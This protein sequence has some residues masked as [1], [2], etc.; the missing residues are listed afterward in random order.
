M[1]KIFHVLKF[2]KEEFIL[3]KLALLNQAIYLI[4]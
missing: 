1:H 4:T 3:N 2:E